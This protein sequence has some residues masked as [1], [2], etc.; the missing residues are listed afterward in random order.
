MVA[1]DAIQWI[2]IIISLLALKPPQLIGYTWKTIDQLE[3]PLSMD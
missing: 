3:Y 2:N 1:L